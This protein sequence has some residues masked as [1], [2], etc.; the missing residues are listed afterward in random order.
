MK[1]FFTIINILGPLLQNGKDMGDYLLDS[2]ED[3]VIRTDNKVDDTLVLPSIKGL[4][5]ALD[6]PDNDEQETE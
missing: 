4:R 3:Y 2:L 1:K 5:A 6:I